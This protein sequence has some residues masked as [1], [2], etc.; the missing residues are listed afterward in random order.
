MKQ[1]RPGQEIKKFRRTVTVDDHVLIMMMYRNEKETLTF[2][3]LFRRKLTTLRMKWVSLR[4]YL[5]VKCAVVTIRA[6]MWAQC[7]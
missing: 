6:E 3:F 4:V 7:V 2:L 5:N 1:A